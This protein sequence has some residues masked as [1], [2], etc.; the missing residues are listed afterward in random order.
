MSQWGTL[1]P[2]DEEVI[3]NV[4]AVAF[5]G[6]TLRHM[7]GNVR[8]LISFHGHGAHPAGTDTVRSIVAYF[9]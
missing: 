1:S 8:A 5:G 7:I 3:K 4:G 2:D 6:M 9:F